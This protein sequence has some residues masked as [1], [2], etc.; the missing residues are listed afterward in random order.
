MNNSD[1]DKRPL[2]TFFIFLLIAVSSHYFSEATI[3]KYTFKP[4]EVFAHE[5]SHGMAA[6]LTGN[7]FQSLHLS[8]NEGHAITNYVGSYHRISQ[9]IVSFSGYFGASILG[10]LIYLS[11]MKFGY[12][13]KAFV[14]GFCISGFWF[15]DG[16]T[17]VLILSYILIIFV[18]CCYFGRGGGY[19]LRFI[20]IYVITE[21]IYSPTYLF[22]Y[23]QKGDH[24][25]LS[26]L[27]YLPSFL[28]ILIW[29]VTSISFL[30]IAYKYT[31]STD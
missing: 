30:Y 26:K 13:R 18:S 28:F 8:W 19:L 15:A 9:I 23:S 5:A 3:I 24:V 7:K 27:T 4:I 17:T 21:A 22:A 11:S 20:G 10:L 6:L 14:V 1:L 25:A 31:Q 2:L 29:M 12:A 16:I